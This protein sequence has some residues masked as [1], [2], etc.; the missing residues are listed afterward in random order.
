MPKEIYY[1]VALLVGL[2]VTTQAGVNAQLN[3]V[4]NNSAVTALISFLVGTVALLAYVLIT[5]HSALPAA[6]PLV[7]APWWKYTGGLFG[8]LYISSI[9]IIAPKIGAANTIGFIVGGQLISA[10]VFDHFGILGFPVKPLTMLR[11]LGVALMVAG[12]YLVRKF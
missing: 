3:L 2:G 6:S 1:L 5:Q 8:V 4:T 9:I 12:V 11:I 10:V 7:Q